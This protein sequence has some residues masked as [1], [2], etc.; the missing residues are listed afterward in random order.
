MKLQFWS[1]IF[2]LTVT[3]VLCG[4]KDLQDHFEQLSGTHHVNPRGSYD[5]GTHLSP[6]FHKENTL[7]NDWS[8]EE[9][10]DDYLDFD[11]LL[12]ED[13]FDIIDAV[14][15]TAPEIKQRNIL[16]LFPGKTRIQRLNILN[17][18]FGFNLYRSLKNKANSSDNILLAPVGISTAM[19]M[20]SLGLRGHTQDEVLTSLGFREFINASSTYNITTIHNIFY[21]LTHRLFRRNFGY[22]LR[23]V[24]DL[25]M[26]KQFPI[27]SEFISNMKKYYV[28]EAQSAD[29]S[30][31]TFITKANERISKLTKGLIK[32]ALERVDPTTLM[33][34]L[35]C[36]YFKGKA[37]KGSSTNA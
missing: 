26:Q 37:A 5:D 32:E 16:A 6:E 24:N 9:E 27:E 36:I 22:T 23:S 35:N 7:T 21:K 28:S 14:P 3:L 11:K 31:P 20:I 10:E 1:A 2:T 4:V 19:A 17:A 30:D 29:F 25:Y 15:E 8:V 12:G 13:Y 34:I 33:M 18:K